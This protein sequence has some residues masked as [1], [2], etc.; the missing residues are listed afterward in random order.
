MDSILSVGKHVSMLCKSL[1]FQIR[2]ISGVRK[3]L[4]ED[5][6]RTLIAALFT[7]RLDYAN[8]L[9]ANAPR[10][11]IDRLQRLQNS[12]ARLITRSSRYDHITPVLFGLHW[13]PVA[14]RVKFKVA[15]MTFKA[16][17]R[18]A[19]PYIAEL[20]QL[21]R[22]V[23]NLRSASDATMLQTVRTRTVNFGDRR[24]SVAAPTIWNALRTNI[25]SSPDVKVFKR[26]LKSHYFMIACDL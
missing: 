21:K 13:L 25:R 4:D 6:L 1:G 7:S 23:R 24:F 11:E 26:L 15:L 16:I 12:A 5:S 18:L 14:F 2:C 10:Y 22:P 19:P 8:A 9:L 20:I 3:F 17:N